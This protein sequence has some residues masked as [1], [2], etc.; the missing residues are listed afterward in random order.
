MDTRKERLFI[1]FGFSLGLMLLALGVLQGAGPQ[2]VISLVLIAGLSAIGC[3]LQG[4]ELRISPR[5]Q[6]GNHEPEIRDSRSITTRPALL[7]V[8]RVIVLGIVFTGAILTTPGTAYPASLRSALACV[9]GP[10]SGTISA[11]EEWCA[12]DNPHILTGDV[13]VGAGVTL[14]IQPGV[15]VKGQ[16]NAQLH[17][18]GHLAALGTPTQPITFTSAADSGPEGWE[19]LVFD[20][21][22]GELRHTTVRYGGSW[23]DFARSN[24]SVL[25]VTGGEVRLESSQVISGSHSGYTDY[26]LY[27]NNSH[28]V[29]SDTLFADTGGNNSSD[30]ALYATGAGTLVTVTN[31]TFQNNAGSGVATNDGQT[32]I[33]C[34]NI[35][36]NN[37]GVYAGT[38]VAPS[39]VVS[40]SNISGNVSYGVRNDNAGVT[41]DAQGNWWGA[42][43]GPRGAGPGSGDVVSGNV[44]V[45]PWLVAVSPCAVLE[46]DIEATPNPVNFGNVVIGGTAIQSITVSNVGWAALNITNVTLPGAPFSIITDNC[47]GQTVPAHSS[48]T[49]DVQFAPG[50]AGSY[51]DSITITSNDPDEP[52]YVVNLL[53]NGV[54]GGVP[55]FSLACAPSSLDIPQGESDTS[56]CTVTSLNGFNAAVDLS[57]DR[58]PAGVTCA[59][60][61]PSVTPP[62]N[63]VGTSTLTVSVAITA[64]VGSSIFPVVGSSGQLRHNAPIALNVLTPSR[65]R[66]EALIVDEHG[67]SLSQNL[68]DTLPQP[69]NLN[70]VLEPNE[71]VMVE[72]GWANLGTHSVSL[73]GRAFH[74]TGPGDPGNYFILDHIAGYGNIPAGSKAICYDGTGDCYILGVAAPLKRPADHWDATFDERLSTGEIKTWKVHIGESFADVSLGDFAYRYIETMLHHRITSGCLGTP[75]KYC[76]GDPTTRGQMAAFIARSLEEI[77]AMTVTPCSVD[78]P[79]PFGD[80]SNDDPFCDDI[81]AIYEAGITAGCGDGSYCPDDPTSRAQMAALVVR[82]L[83]WAGRM[84]EPAACSVENPSPFSDVPNDYI[85]CPQIKALYDAGVVVGCIEGMYCPDADAL[86]S[87]SAI[88]IVNGFQFKLYG[89]EWAESPC[90]TPDFDSDGDVDVKDLQTLAAAWRDSPPADMCYDRDGDSKVTIIDIMEVARSLGW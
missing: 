78:N 56:T 42:A 85:F 22:T 17:V 18:Q 9:S 64:P 59:F 6:L 62:A 61:P 71:A 5:S 10:H 88:V 50:A 45:D 41:V 43:D 32:S 35:A 29:I 83:V 1:P 28:V 48:C 73:A 3:R 53:G 89:P 57:C 60:N 36:S 16:S 65:L 13:T 72:P 4:A 31:S 67:Y 90:A 76:P 52:N 49:I 2:I 27:V 47:S 12:A 25:N 44:L 51:T 69:P 14:T 38:G 26:G 77:G 19:G 24:L 82:A 86:R 23:D 8:G 20:G 11:S 80:V 37:I 15:V 7:G 70:G 46:P 39:V 34:S 30:S 75:F 21:G 66:A 81:K 54:T 40:D 33:S 68:I 55:D 58:E 63:G 87:Q 74:F 79:S 84:A